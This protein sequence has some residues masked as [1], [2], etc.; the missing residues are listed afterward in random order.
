MNDF[1][2]YRKAAFAVAFGLT[3]GKFVGDIVVKVG[4][5]I[6]DEICN[7]LLAVYARKGHEGAKKLCEKYDIKYEKE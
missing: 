1:K 3:T 5:G 7:D 2:Y 6:L 4:Q